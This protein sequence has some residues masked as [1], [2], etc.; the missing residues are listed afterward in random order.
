MIYSKALNV[1]P[2]KPGSRWP[3]TLKSTTSAL[4]GLRGKH[5]AEPRASR[6]RCLTAFFLPETDFLPPKWKW[7]RRDR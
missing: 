7:L 6:K 3:P 2:W 5:D 4:P 1:K